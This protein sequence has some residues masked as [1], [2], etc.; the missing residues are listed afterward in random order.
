MS[1]L[2]RHG[3][4]NEETLTIDESESPLV[5][6]MFMK[7]GTVCF[8]VCRVLLRIVVVVAVVVMV[9]SGELWWWYDRG[10]QGELRCGDASRRLAQMERRAVETQRRRHVERDAPSGNSR[11]RRKK[12]RRTK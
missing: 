3:S 11:T 8:G 12:N 4:V 2:N 1:F 7:K 10:F 6:R 5:S 9:V